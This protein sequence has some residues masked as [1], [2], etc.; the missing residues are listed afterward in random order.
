MMM[1]TDPVQIFRGKQRSM[2]TLPEKIHRN[3]E[4]V[5]CHAVEPVE[6]VLVFLRK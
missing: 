5:A 6:M 3:G 2:E 1:I 4:V